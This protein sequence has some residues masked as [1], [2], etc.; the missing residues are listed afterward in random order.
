MDNIIISN[1]RVIKFYKK[2]PDIDITG[3]NLLVIDMLERVLDKSKP[4]DLAQELLNKFDS[5]KGEMKQQI[6]DANS[7]S[8]NN[9]RDMLRAEVGV[10]A[11]SNNIGKKLD[12]MS[13]LQTEK[14]KNDITSTIQSSVGDKLV[15]IDVKNEE[16]TTKFN[17]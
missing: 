9:L 13:G 15:R 3:M 7:D 4:I 17:E 14:I 6:Q 16:L 1:E 8:K 10:D 11:I 2:H 12:S 5:L